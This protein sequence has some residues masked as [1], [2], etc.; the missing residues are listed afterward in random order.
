MQLRLEGNDLAQS[1][2]LAEALAKYQEALELA[3]DSVRHKLH[4]NIS[5]LQ[6]TRGYTEAALAAA[7]AA[8]AAAPRDWST[9]RLHFHACARA[10]WRCRQRLRT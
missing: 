7:E 6:L 8:V 2:E 1:G 10:A 5:L 9:V 4:S 3:P